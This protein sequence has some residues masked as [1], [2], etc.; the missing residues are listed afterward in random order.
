[1]LHL[2]LSLGIKG[3]H[4]YDIVEFRQEKYVAPY[5]QI[6]KDK[7]AETESTFEKVQSASLKK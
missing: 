2:L 6:L 4:C 1:M 7:R 3:D 5:I